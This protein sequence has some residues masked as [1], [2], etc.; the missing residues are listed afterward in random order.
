MIGL[1]GFP[2]DYGSIMHY[3]TDYFSKNGKPTLLP[4]VSGAQIGNRNGLSFQDSREIIAVYSKSSKSRFIAPPL[5]FQVAL[6]L[7]MI[8]A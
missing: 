5:I 3:G 2:Y 6:F 1:M 8:M 4:K 7:V